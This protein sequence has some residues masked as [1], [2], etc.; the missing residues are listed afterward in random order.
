MRGVALLV[1]ISG[2]TTDRCKSNTVLLTYALSGGAEAADTIDVTLAVGGGA[3]QTRSVA[4]KSSD[5]S[6]EV[7]FGT[8]PAGQSLSFTLTARA[9]GDVLGQASRTAVAE[10]GCTTLSF[11]L[12]GGAGDLSRPDLSSIDLPAVDLVSR[13]D[14]ADG[15]APPDLV[16]VHDLSP[17]LVLRAYPPAAVWVAP[18]GGGSANSSQLNLC[19][20]QTPVGTSQ[21]SSN[22]SLTFGF[23][24]S[25][26]Y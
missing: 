1:I 15:A 8:Y 24:A 11:Q 6:I 21:S 18:G 12:E 3:A 9:G 26:T 25:D 2:C 22:A 16:E 7:D 10:S 23:F 20:G 5:R 14:L 4:R 17:I 13:D 19:A